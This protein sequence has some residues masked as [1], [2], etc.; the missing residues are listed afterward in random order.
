MQAHVVEEELFP[1][2]LR[3]RSESNSTPP[4]RWHGRCG[5]RLLLDRRTASLSLSTLGAL[6]VADFGYPP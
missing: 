1:I 2:F 4:R 5:C 3:E 6:R